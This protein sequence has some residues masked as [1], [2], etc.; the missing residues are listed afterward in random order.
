MTPSRTLAQKADPSA[1]TGH[2]QQ[3]DRVTLL[4]ATNW[5]GTCK[6]KPLLIGKFGK[7]R[8]FATTKMSSLPVEYVHSKNAWMT[9][10]LFEAWFKKTFVPSAHQH[11]RRLG[12]PEK[13]VLLLDNCPAHPPAPTLVSRDGHFKAFFLPKNTTSKIQPLDQGT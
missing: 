5:A 1:T 8:C 9:A 6:V 13:G 7:P 10:S 4:L 3:K 12:C 11:L 2:K